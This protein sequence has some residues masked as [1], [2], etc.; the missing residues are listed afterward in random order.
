MRKHLLVLLTAFLSLPVF[1]QSGK[2]PKDAFRSPLDIPLV[3]SGTFGELRGNH[4][5]SGIDIKTEGREG[6]KVFAAADGEIVR[7]NVSPWG[8]GNALYVRHPNGFTTVYAHLQRFSTEIQAYVK[9][10]QYRNQTFEVELYP[11][12]GTFPVKS[13]DVIA[14][15]GNSGGSGGPHLHFEIR[16]T[17]TEEPINPLLFGFEVPDHRAPD[18][19][20]IT[21]V[22][23]DENSWVEDGREKLIPLG[24]N[25]F[26]VAKTLRAYGNV[27]LSTYVIDRLDGAWN[28]N[29]IFFIDQYVDSVQT[30]HFDTER[31]AFHETRYINA[32]MDYGEYLHRG[33][34]THRTFRLPCDELRMYGELKQ[35]GVIEVLPGQTRT[36]RLVA[37]DVAGNTTEIEVRIA[38][39]LPEHHS[40]PDGNRYPCQQVNF[41]RIDGL[42]AV[43]KAGSFYS[44]AWLTTSLEMGK[45]SIPRYSIE[46][47]DIPVH[48]RFDLSIAV[49]PA[50]SSIPGNQL[51]IL[52]KDHRN[53]LDYEGGKLENGRI[54]TRPRD[55]G[56]FYI[57]VD[58]IPP[59]IR[60]LNISNG[61]DLTGWRSIRIKVSD[62][63]SGLSEYKATIDG[64]WVL[65]E[66][67][68]KYDLL[69]HQFEDDFPS[70]EHV[71]SLEV[72]DDRGNRTS[73]QAHFSR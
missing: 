11:P 49:P 58:S 62:D 55:L 2:Y 60:P 50:L 48:H 39:V 15:S 42:E 9:R 16:D 45:D 32:H 54:S 25:R 34:K 37:G 72:A 66:Y 23:L 3:L 33:R 5:H 1:G 57:G 20:Y 53:R 46:P 29:G 7:I 65:M 18:P 14:L 63:L 61:K 30:F 35:D 70:G 64:K 26:K 17:R 47:V 31:L 52:R 59:V 28:S 43:F 10:A 12:K 71:F 44:D 19:E 6:K 56:T 73:F 68:A 27:G 67:D 8:Y 24:N 4:F 41:F 38:G 21:L 22:P 40:P 51:C 36:V 13:G 69:Y